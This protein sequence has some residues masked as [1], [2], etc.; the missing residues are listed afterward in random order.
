ML[1][2]FL[3]LECVIFMICKFIHTSHIFITSIS[4]LGAFAT[5]L[6]LISGNVYWKEVMGNSEFKE[7]TKK[8]Y[9]CRG[10]KVS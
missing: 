6:E 9:L 5:S 1:R 2:F 7:D 8:Y 3:I 4:G 10:L